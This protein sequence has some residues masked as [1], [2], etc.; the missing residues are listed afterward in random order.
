MPQMNVLAMVQSIANDMESDPVN[1]IS[2]TVEAEQITQI[3]KDTYY[4]LLEHKDWGRQ[5]KMLTLTETSATTP[6]VFQIPDNV[7]H[8]TSLKY[9]NSDDKY[10][11]LIREDPEEFNNRML[12]NTSS[13]SNVVAQV[14][15]NSDLTIYVLTDRQP[16]F[17]TSYDDYYIVMDA[18]DSTVDSYLRQAKLITW[19]EAFPTWT[20]SDTF[21]PI[22]PDNM[23]SYLLAEAKQRCFAHIKQMSSPVVAKQARQGAI[24][25]QG[26]KAWKQNGGPERANFGR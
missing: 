21:V 1:S 12:G 26:H 2:D 8:L 9:K 6:T 3:L 22:F 19:G 11:D 16:S 20:N 4:E 18:Y 7:T 17:W 14:I 10:V 25:S 13:M 15:P 5:R 23:Y 24:R